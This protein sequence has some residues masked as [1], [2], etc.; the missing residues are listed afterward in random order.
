MSTSWAVAKELRRG[1]GS[2]QRA[3]G[4]VL[5]WARADLEQPV[6]QTY[7]GLCRFFGEDLSQKSCRHVSCGSCWRTYEFVKFVFFNCLARSFFK[8]IYGRFT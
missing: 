4:G 2:A 6:Q 1:R 8:E 5:A 7:V 3:Q